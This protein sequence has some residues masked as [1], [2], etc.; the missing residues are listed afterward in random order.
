M[1][2]RNLK[3]VVFRPDKVKIEGTRR[4]GRKAEVRI[5]ANWF[6]VAN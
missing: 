6:V 1:K 4:N 5:G 3:C 2:K